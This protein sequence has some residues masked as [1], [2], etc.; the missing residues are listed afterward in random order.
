MTLFTE[1]LYQDTCSC[2]KI[3]DR[4]PFVDKMKRCPEYAIQYILFNQSCIL[5]IQ[6]TLNLEDNDLQKSLHRDILP[7]HIEPRKSGYLVNLLE[8]CRLFPL[9]HAYMFYLGLLSGGNLLRKYIPNQFHSI[10][11]F[12]EEPKEIIRKFKDFLNSKII[13]E[14]DQQQFIDRV[15]TSYMMVEK[16]FDYL[17]Q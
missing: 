5:E 3:V 11:T 17:L 8:A 12:E 2:H 6:K 13:T 15:K 1:R 9:E 4:H 10:L 16:C 7:G 14:E